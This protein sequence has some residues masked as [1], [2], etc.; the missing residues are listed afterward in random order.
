MLFRSTVVEG[1]GEGELEELP[2][3]E[4]TLGD[5][6][7]EGGT[8]PVRL[9]AQVTEVG[10]LALWC[11]ARGGRRRWKLEFNVRSR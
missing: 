10:T 5:G 11:V 6:A 4:T 7:E 1:W 3:L 2:P 8:V 9:E